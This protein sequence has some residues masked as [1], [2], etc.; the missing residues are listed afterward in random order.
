MKKT[1]LGTLLALLVI[2]TT[3]YAAEAGYG[4]EAGFGVFENVR[5]IK[6]TD[7]QIH[8]DPK[9]VLKDFYGDSDKYVALTVTTDEI[10]NSIQLQIAPTMHFRKNL[11][12]DI[13]FVGRVIFADVYQTKLDVKIGGVFGYGKIQTSVNTVTTDNFL[14]NGSTLQ[15]INNTGTFYKYG[16]TAGLS[17]PI[18]KSFELFMNIDWINRKYNFKQNITTANGT[19]GDPKAAQLAMENYK[20]ESL[21]TS[22]GISYTF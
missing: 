5:Q 4:I 21:A 15:T 9:V 2:R 19:G 1:K 13:D 7:Y 8:D 14:L 6:D 12:Y 17:Y 20:I 3:T 22:L 18:Y 11:K 16:L 10:M